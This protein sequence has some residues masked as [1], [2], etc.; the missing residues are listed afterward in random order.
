MGGKALC[1]FC[2]AWVA[3]ADADVAG[4]TSPHVVCIWF[5]SIWMTFW[6]VVISTSVLS[7]TNDL[8]QV[9]AIVCFADDCGR[10][11]QVP[12]IIEDRY[13]LAGNEWRFLAAASLVMVLNT[14]WMAH[15]LR[16]SCS[17]LA[18][19][20][21]FLICCSTVVHSTHWYN[22]SAGKCK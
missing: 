12:G 4:T 18:C 15:W 21:V 20:S 9:G 10:E 2:S 22:I 6:S 3:E 8:D 7:T 17:T 16:W 5:D 13:S 11:P 19:G 1:G 14:L